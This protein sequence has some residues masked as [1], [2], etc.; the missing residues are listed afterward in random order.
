MS[1]PRTSRLVVRGS[2]QTGWVWVGWGYQG[3]TSG[4]YWGATSP[5]SPGGSGAGA[6]VRGDETGRAAAAP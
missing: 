3:A 5:E 6:A 1:V 4:G 2:E